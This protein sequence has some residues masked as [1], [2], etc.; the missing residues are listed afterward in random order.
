VFD[1][2]AP[3]VFLCDRTLKALGIDDADHA[4]IIVHGEPTPVFRSS[5]HFE[6]VNIV[7]ASYFLENKLKMEVNYNTRKFMVRNWLQKKGQN[8]ENCS[9]LLVKTKWEIRVFHFQF[10]AIFILNIHEFA[11]ILYDQFLNCCWFP[12]NILINTIRIR[13]RNWWNWVE[14]TTG[15]KIKKDFQITLE[16]NY[17]M[18]WTTSNTTTWL[19]D[20]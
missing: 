11:L 18:K 4:F 3:E 13:W 19:L 10:N 17:E 15:K 8:F 14:G 12:C 6:E 9:L 5:G 7:G 1:T 2:A 20:Y 16:L